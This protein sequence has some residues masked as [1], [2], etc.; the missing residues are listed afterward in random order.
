M[1]IM[2]KANPPAPKIEYTIRDPHCREIAGHVI[3]EGQKTIYLTEVEARF[4][5]SSGGLAPVYGAAPAQKP[6]PH[7]GPRPV[8]GRVRKLAKDL[9]GCRSTQ[10]ASPGSCRHGSADR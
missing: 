7:A 4:F 5:L 3:S 6:E 8:A 2:T 10:N 1:P 9:A